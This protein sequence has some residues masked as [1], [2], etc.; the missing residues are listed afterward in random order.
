[1]TIFLKKYIINYLQTYIQDITTKQQKQE[2]LPG[3]VKT[4]NHKEK[5]IIKI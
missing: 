5:M 1:M 2:N 3:V 4:K